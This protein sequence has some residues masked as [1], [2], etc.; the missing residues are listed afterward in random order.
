MNKSSLIVLT[1]VLVSS[2]VLMWYFH[3]NTD[4]QYQ[5]VAITENENVNSGDTKDIITYQNASADLIQVELPFPGAVTGKDFGVI[6][7][8]R[9]YWFFEGSFPIEVR[10][11]SG[12]VLATSI[13]TA[14][15]EWMTEDFVK[16]ASE[17]KIPESYIGPATLIL[18]KD[19]P[20]GLPAHDASISFPITIEY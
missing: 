4:G 14:D 15:G 13:A 6:G 3:L 20:S 17:I 7:K 11:R 2:F 18:K 12:E 9:G 5:E 16:F 19:N 1:T 8:A 10:E